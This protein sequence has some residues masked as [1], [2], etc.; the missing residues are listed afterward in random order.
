ML[1]LVR[2]LLSV[3]I[4]TFHASTFGGSVNT[5]LG[6]MDIVVESIEETSSDH[7][8]KTDEEGLDVLPFVHFTRTHRVVVQCTHGPSNRPALLPK[9]RV[10]PSLALGDHFLVG[11]LLGLSMSSSLLRVDWCNS[12]LCRAFLQVLIAK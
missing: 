4:D 10:E 11:E 2:I 12:I 6:S 7:G 1:D 5:R 9:F 8:G 3:C